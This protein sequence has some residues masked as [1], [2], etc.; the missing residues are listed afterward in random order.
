MQEQ[1]GKENRW[2]KEESLQVCKNAISVSLAFACSFRATLG[3]AA[4]AAFVGDRKGSSDV[5]SARLARTCSALPPTISIFFRSARSHVCECNCL[6]ERVNVIVIN[7]NLF[8]YD[9]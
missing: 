9:K 4:A 1:K 7:A 6:S 8:H 2:R 5:K 3:C